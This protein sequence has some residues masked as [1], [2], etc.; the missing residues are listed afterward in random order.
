[1]TLV[2]A[3]FHLTRVV[4]P[5]T[6]ALLKFDAQHGHKLSHCKTSAGQLRWAQECSEQAR[7]MITY[8]KRQDGRSAST[9][10][11]SPSLQRLKAIMRRM[12]AQS[13]S[14]ETLD[15]ALDNSEDRLRISVTSFAREN[16]SR[17]SVHNWS[18]E[19]QGNNW[20]RRQTPASDSLTLARR[21]LP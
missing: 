6:M 2:R 3:G 17:E 12:A 11:S 15:E 13:A 5:L 7:L 18:R 4:K 8:V 16:A 9:R 21:W 10:S 1:M 19:T 20:R 14:K